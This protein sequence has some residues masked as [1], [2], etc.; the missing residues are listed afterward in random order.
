MRMYI[1]MNIK[2][3]SKTLK[4]FIVFD[5]TILYVIKKVQRD[6]DKSMLITAQIIKVK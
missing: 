3:I 1:K 4:F 6:S 5:P 2:Y